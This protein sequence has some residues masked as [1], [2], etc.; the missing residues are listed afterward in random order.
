M[1]QQEALASGSTRFTGKI[2]VKHPELGGERNLSNHCIGCRRALMRTPEYLEKRRIR[3]NNTPSLRARARAK[4]LAKRLARQQTPEYCASQLARQEVRAKRLARQEADA[5]RRAYKQTPEYL[6][7]L[8][9]RKRERLYRYRLTPAFRMKRRIKR[10]CDPQIKINRLIK[11]SVKRSLRSQGIDDHQ[12][13]R[14]GCS[15]KFLVQYLEQQLPPWCTVIDRNGW[16]LDHIRPIASFDLTDPKQRRACWHYTNLRMIPGSE[17]IQKSSIWRGWLWSGGR[18]VRR[19][20][21]D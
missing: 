15:R 7:Q 4:R 16:H 17:N 14:T 19:V 21:P 12:Q 11:K 20:T 18:R 5:E 10:R 9:I 6:E 1:T 13:I 8:R 2:C 3:W